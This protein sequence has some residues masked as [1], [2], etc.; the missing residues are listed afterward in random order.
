MSIAPNPLEIFRRAAE[1]GERRLDQSLLELVATSFI[2]GFTIVFG[3]AALGVVQAALAPLPGKTAA[4]AGALAFGIGLA[5]LVVGRA[6]LFTENFFDP[7]ATL[8]A[9][10]EPALLPRIARLWSV[11]LVLNLVGGLLLTLALAVPGTIPEEAGSVL[12]ELAS[13]IAERPSWGIFMSGIV[14][15]AL[16]SV[17]SYMLQAVG[18]VGARAWLAYSVGFLL[19]IGPF[20][21]VVV[22]LLH[23]AFGVFFGAP[24]DAALIAKVGAL[25][26]AG[27]LVG[28]VGLVTMSHVAQKK[29]AD[30]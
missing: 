19:A 29:G 24:L 3:I 13:H 16:V 20:D 26:L 4:I 2:A 11:T 17:L 9:R 8:F 1:E 18:S 14:G 28:G 27:N 21:H 10:R 25:A 15:G 6:E 7:V 5:Y 23:L 12:G 22:T 30:E